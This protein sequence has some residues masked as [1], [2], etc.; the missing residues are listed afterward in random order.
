MLEYRL[1]ELKN[2]LNGINIKNKAD[3]LGISPNAFIQSQSSNFRKF[4]GDAPFKVKYHGTPVKN[5]TVFPN[6]KHKMYK[7]KLPGTGT[8]EE[9]I[10]VSSNPSYAERYSYSGIGLY[11]GSKTGDVH[12][13][14]IGGNPTSL[15]ELSSL[16]VTDN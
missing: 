6:P 10:Y 13:V 1:L 4:L 2:G 11:P 12:Q 16:G 5:A 8:Y 3:A 14:V 15:N 7:G 9:G